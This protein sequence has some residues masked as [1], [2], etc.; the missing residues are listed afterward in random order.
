MMD[1][2]YLEKA[3]SNATILSTQTSVP[4]RSMSV[5]REIFR[6]K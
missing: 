2:G 3:L 5:R 4:T 1:W 6:Q